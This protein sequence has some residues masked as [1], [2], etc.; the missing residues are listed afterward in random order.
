MSLLSNF[1]GT[2]IKYVS[3]IEGGWTRSNAVAGDRRV[4]MA[5]S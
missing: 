3:M 2:S 5:E 1:T 4:I